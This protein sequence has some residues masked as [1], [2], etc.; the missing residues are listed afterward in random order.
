MKSANKQTSAKAY[1]EAMGFNTD[2][3]QK[4]ER[5]KPRVIAGGCLL[6]K[7]PN[8]RVQLTPRPPLHEGEKQPF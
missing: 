2:K 1:F 4:P 6:Y 7:L 8:S 5:P 3:P